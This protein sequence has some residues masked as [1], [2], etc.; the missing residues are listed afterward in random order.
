MAVTDTAIQVMVTDVAAIQ[1]VVTD[2]VA[3]LC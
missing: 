1:L 2:V 3:A